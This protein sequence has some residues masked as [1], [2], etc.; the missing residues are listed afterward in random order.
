ML[1]LPDLEV[2]VLQLY[3]L[4][5]FPHMV[6]EQYGTELTE[7]LGE[8]LVVDGVE[9]FLRRYAPAL[10]C[11]WFHGPRCHPWSSTEPRAGSKLPPGV[12]VEEWLWNWISPARS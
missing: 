1:D 11:T 10:T 3:P 2:A 4:L 5:V 9:M 6:F 8:R 12:S 7:E